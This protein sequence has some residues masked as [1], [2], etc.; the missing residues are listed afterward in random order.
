MELLRANGKCFNCKSRPCRVGQD[1]VK[2]YGLCNGMMVAKKEPPADDTCGFSCK[3]PKPQFAVQKPVEPLEHDCET[4]GLAVIFNFNPDQGYH[5]DASR[6]V[7]LRCI[8]H[9]SPIHSGKPVRLFNPASGQKRQVNEAEF[10]F[11]CGVASQ[12][13]WQNIMG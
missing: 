8:T 4:A 10:V 9:Q 1:I 6:E 12:L 5:Y 13:S 11:A 7:R 2:H 3:Q